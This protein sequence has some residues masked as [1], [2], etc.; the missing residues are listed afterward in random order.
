[1]DPSKS[2]SEAAN[3]FIAKAMTHS[4]YDFDKPLFR[5]LSALKERFSGK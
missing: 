1:M 2:E 5:S 3:A 4:K